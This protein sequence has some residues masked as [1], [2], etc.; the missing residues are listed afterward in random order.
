ML[1]GSSNLDITDSKPLILEAPGRLRGS[2][3]EAP[4]TQR[5]A[6]ACLGL[7]AEKQPGH[8]ERLG[9]V[10]EIAEGLAA[11]A[12]SSDESCSSEARALLERFGVS[13]PLAK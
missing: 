5:E 9:Q 10:D 7:I 6:L 3:G 4:G 2:S 11:A 1:N 12:S 13:S 8:C